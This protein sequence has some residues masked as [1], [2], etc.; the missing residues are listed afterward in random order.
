MTKAIL[1]TLLTLAGLAVIAWDSTHSAS[2]GI[3]TYVA[4]ALAM[5]APWV[6][7]F[8]AVWVY[9]EWRKRMPAKAKRYG[10]AVWMMDEMDLGDC[11]ER[12]GVMGRDEGA[13]YEDEEDGE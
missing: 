2:L 7:I 5:M 9:Q 10:A 3:P 6:V 12:G 11:Y 4:G 8:G 13:C 1:A